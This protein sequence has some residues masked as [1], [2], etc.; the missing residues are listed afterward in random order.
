M[1][2]SPIE[3]LNPMNEELSVMRESLL[4]SLLKNMVFN[5]RHGNSYG[6]LFEISPVQYREKEHFRE[7]NHLSLIF[8]G[9]NSGDCG[10]RK[11]TIM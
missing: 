1:S 11:K 5:N 4:P 9:Q 3:L 8:W 2:D 6:R 10:V 7:Q